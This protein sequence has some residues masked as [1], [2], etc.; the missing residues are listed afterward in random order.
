MSASKLHAFRRS[1]FIIKAAFILLTA[2]LI[3]AFLFFCR[4]KTVTVENNVYSATE[5]IL[6]ASG[7]SKGKHIY[8]IDKDAITAAIMAKNPYVR[9][10]SVR[11]SLPSTLR[12]IVTEDSPVFYTASGGKF[13]LLSSSL[14]VLEEAE[15]AY[16][17]SSKGVI[18]IMLPE[19]KT[20]SVGKKLVFTG[21]NSD[22][23]SELVDTFLSSEIAAG[24]SSISISQKFDISAV[25][26][27]KYTLVFGSYEN[28]EKKL[29]FCKKSIAYV[30]SNMPGVSGKMFATG[31][32][33]VSFLVTGT[34]G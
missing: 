33:E 34:A 15:S 29:Y 2:V 18:P 1:A 17:L 31:T 19:I 30:E 4:I 21:G 20:A 12:I 16:G 32:D 5:D 9:S 26:K 27:S 23:Y 22:F 14:R 11:R 13:Y 10:V 25:Y 3:L 8:S 7:V 24:L 6:S 28:L